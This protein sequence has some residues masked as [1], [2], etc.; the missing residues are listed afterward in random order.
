M[1]NYPIVLIV[2]SFLKLTMTFNNR[3][4]GSKK[5]ASEAE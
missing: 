2:F 3:G 1:S 4:G 5:E